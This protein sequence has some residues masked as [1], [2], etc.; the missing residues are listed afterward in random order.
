MKKVISKAIS[1]SLFLALFMFAG[2]NFHWLKGWIFVV[3]VLVQ[4]LVTTFYLYLKNPALLEERSSG[5]TKENQKEWDKLLLK[6]YMISMPLWILIMP[7]DAQRFHLTQ[8]FGF[9]INAFG[10]ALMIISSILVFLTLVQNTFASHT[11]RIQEERG[12]HV[13]SDGLYGIVRHPMYA[14]SFLWCIGTPLFLDSFAGLIFGMFIILIFI[15]RIIGE[16]KMLTQELDGY[17]E[18]KNKVKFRVVPFIW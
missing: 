13:I 5:F 1:L 6:V 11:V 3:I 14:S 2:G 15:V 16:E 4:I 17:E 8:P 10:F 9:Y 7:L 18:Y 12:Q